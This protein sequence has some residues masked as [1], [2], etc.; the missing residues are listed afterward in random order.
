MK[1]LTLAG[2][3]LLAIV[4]IAGASV[5]SGDSGREFLLQFPEGVAKS[6]AGAGELHAPSGV[7]TDSSGKRVYVSDIRNSRIDV[8]SPWGEFIEAFGWGVK[9]GAS[10]L[11][12]C[13]KASGCLVGLEGAGG[14]QFDWPEGLAVDS[15]DNLYVVD[16]KN[17]RVEKFSPSGAFLL[18]FGGDVNRTKVEE[19][20]ST[21]AQRNL[22]T[23]ASG[24]VC[25]IGSTGTGDGQF[26]GWREVSSIAVGPD[27]NV[28]VADE[29]RIQ[30][31]EA[32]GAYLKSIRFSEIHE[33]DEEFP[34]TGESGP[35][36]IDPESGDLYFAFYNQGLSEHS[37]SPNV[38][39]LSPAGKLVD[40]L[41]VD[42][43]TALTID[44]DG[45]VFVG[46]GSHPLHPE[47]EVL[48][49]DP[50][51]K[52]VAVV[53]RS[54][55]K[56]R[57]LG[58]D[59]VGDLYMPNFIF[60]GEERSWVDVYGTPPSE[61]EPAPE[62]APTIADQYAVSASASGAVL[63]A[64]INPHFFG[65]STYYVEYGLEPCKDEGCV[66][67]PAPPGSP[68]A[69]GEKGVPLPTSRVPISGLAPATTYHYRFVSVSGKFTVKGAG[70]DSNGKPL[71]LEGTFTTRPAGTPTLPDGRAYEKVSPADK[72][73]GEAGLT[74]EPL[75][76]W[77]ESS[78]VVRPLQASPSGE[79]ITFGSFSVFGQAGG[80]PATSQYLSRR[81]ASGWGSEN[82]TPAARGFSLRGPVRGFSAEL[83]NSVVVQ[84]DPPLV[85]GA[86]LGVENLY[87][88]DEHGGLTLLTPEAPKDA[89]PAYCIGYG[90]A[91]EDF[92]RVMF[93][94]TGQLTSD[95]LPGSGQNLYEWIAGAGLKLVSVL[96][97]G[98]PAPPTATTGFGSMISSTCL[99]GG[100][101]RNAVSADGSQIVWTYGGKYEGSEEPLFARV[102]GA[103]TVQLD[104]PQG[105]TGPG[106][107][108]HYRAA[109]AN[110]S[111]VFFTAPGKLLA[112]SKAGDLYRY[113]FG[114]GEGERLSDLTLAPKAAEVQGVLGASDDGSAIYFAAKGVLSGA[115]ENSEG[116]KAVAGG[117][118]IYGWSMGVGL[119]FIASVNA[120]TDETAWSP[121]SL[122]STSRV[123]GDGTRLAFGSTAPLTGLDNTDQATGKADSEVFLYDAVSNELTCASCNPT[124]AR[125]IG[126]ATLPPWTT[127]FEQPRN[128]SEGAVRLF[129]QSKDALALKDTNGRQDV[130]Q[131][132]LAGSGGCST[133]S[134]SYN[135]ASGGCQDLIS[136]GESG[137]EAY[138]DDSSASGADVF[139]ATRQRLLPS[140]QDDHYDIYDARVGGGFPEPPPHS[141]CNAEACRPPVP[142]PGAAAPPASSTFSGPGNEKEARK[143]KKHKSKKHKGQKKHKSKKQKRQNLQEVGK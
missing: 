64:Q 119:R 104:L 140:D 127:P 56:P 45:N 26:E 103:E 59:R 81:G 17:H 19:V 114:A 15:T 21:E 70:E 8:F 25:Q 100:I 53:V 60:V 101:A 32:G 39:R 10:E 87:L 79:A 41:E 57:S 24:D 92:S 106:G 86:P 116:Q 22:C 33:D 43:P 4:L 58:I 3:A 139:F 20:G 99:S 128:I 44:L 50:S 62:R 68:L 88:R 37:P 23:A 137:D 120:A 54:D 93:M 30:V 108:G 74:S 105:G 89:V 90:G 117:S 67:T 47:S 27:A 2:A 138:L 126:P 96:P 14:G 38:Y 36:A 109:S 98:N 84:F 71:G 133:E 123:S 121:A 40:K 16:L 48:E 107:N 112:G 75:G 83:S 77:A 129:F 65:S 102:D 82:V 97:D 72:N 51:G 73:S 122:G 132:E 110:G 61:I 118:N 11:Q 131:F 85:P 134:A 1:K 91:S 142:P 113:D 143:P 55:R 9:N 42:T 35:L 111:T 63:K 69:G 78:S 5:A 94:A 76:G 66:S 49:F 135:T 115:E 29:D 52:A 34:G 124:G 95:A 80:A 125:P 18:M 141:E 13:T 12:S 46:E 136:S 28:Y 7:V 130:Y 6:G 31:F